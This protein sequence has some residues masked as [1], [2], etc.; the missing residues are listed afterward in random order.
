MKSKVFCF[1]FSKKK[2]PFFLEKRNQKTFIPM[3]V[4]ALVSVSSISPAQEDTGR[5][6]PKTLI[7]DEPGIDD[8]VSLPTLIVLPQPGGH[9]TDLDFE[10]D[11][12]LTT[13]LS[14]QINIGYTV[15]PRPGDSSVAGWQNGNATLK[16]VVLDNRKTERL[17]SVSLTREFGGSGAARIGALATSATSLA[18]NFGQGFAEFA[19]DEPL[20]QPFAV[21]G[22]AGYTVPDTETHEA[23]REA[24]I[25]ASL[26]YSFDVLLAKATNMRLAPFLRP[27]LPIVEASFTVPDSAG[28]AT[29]GLLAPGLIYAGEGYQ[30]AA[31]A[32]LPLTRAAGTH[33]GLIAQINISLGKIAGPSWAH[34]LF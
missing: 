14:L 27:F 3:A 1:F 17:V 32:L 9:E 6:F 25:S 22:S 2:S 21:T 30:L 5:D 11:K 28:P 10:L 26:Q 19:S 23:A 24:V 18:V 13:R 7:F 29:R 34:P 20:L 31:E 15:L 16:F 8:E 4:A 33:A 12:R